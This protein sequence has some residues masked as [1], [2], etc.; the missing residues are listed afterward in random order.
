M[1][2]VLAAGVII[3]RITDN[4]REYLLLEKEPNSSEKWAPPKG[5]V[6]FL[7]L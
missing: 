2:Q 3:F 1:H 6:K 5:T 7:L 4:L